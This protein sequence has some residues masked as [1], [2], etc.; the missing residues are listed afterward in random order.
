[1]WSYVKNILL[2][3]VYLCFMGMIAWAVSYMDSTI[4]E[5]FLCF[6]NVAF[7]CFIMWYNLYKEDLYC[8]VVLIAT[9]NFQC[10]R[11]YK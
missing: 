11:W 9:I 6:V 2:G 10:S 3:Y 7:F 1:M 5:F 4:A 8:K